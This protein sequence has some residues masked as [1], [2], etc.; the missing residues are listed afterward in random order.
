ML[1]AQKIFLLFTLFNVVSFNFVSGN[2]ITLYALRLGAG[3]FLVGAL[4]SFVPLARLLPL[5]GRLMVPR[6][7]ITRLMGVFWFVRYLVM[8]PVLFAPLFAG[9]G[10]PGTALILC[11][12]GV[13]GFNIARGIAITGYNPVLG[14]IT[15]GRD[16]GSYIAKNQVVVHSTSILTGIITALLLGEESPLFIY[17]IILA[18][19][20]ASGI[21]ASQFVFRLPEPPRTRRAVRS[22]LV[23]GVKRSLGRKSVRKFYLV[24]FL[25]FLGLAMIQ[26]FLIVFMRLVYGQGDN[27]VVYLTVIGSVGAI[28]TAFL[29]GFM[30]DRIGAKP[31][32]FVFA[33]LVAIPLVPLMV[34][35]PLMGVGLWLYAGGIFFLFMMGQAGL[36]N[37]AH[38]YFFAL[39]GPEERLNLGILYSMT[40]GLA[41]TLGSLLGGTLLAQLQRSRLAVGEVFTIYFGILSALYMVVLFLAA[42]LEKLGAYGIRDA[43]TFLLSPRD[44]RAMGLLHRLDR[45]RT[46]EEEKTFIQALGE[47]GSDISTSDLLQRLRSPRFTLRAEALRALYHLSPDEDVKRALISEAKNHRYTTA[48]IAAELIG[49]HGIQ[50]G[51]KVLRQALRSRD[52]FLSGKSMVALARLGDRQSLTTITGILERTANP[53]LIIHAAT[54]CELFKEP[55][56]IPLLIK[57]LKQRTSAYVRDEI[58]LSVAGIL[59]VDSF[60]YPLYTRFLER[61]SHGIAELRDFLQTSARRQVKPALDSAALE[62]LLN[63]LAK[64]KRVFMQE[65]D[66]LLAQLQVASGSAEAVEALQSGTTDAHYLRLD[67]F[68]FLVA[69]VIIWFAAGSPEDHSSHASR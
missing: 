53:R 18:L 44:L 30:V 47:S 17:T 12:V 8:A 38:T 32:Y 41:G 45:S 22:G 24:L 1:R 36:G 58:I 5:V 13:L 59:G 54:A 10:N 68:C 11:I 27:S 26:P 28:A 23:A 6:F 31:L 42:G 35:P 21:V 4:A 48:Y 65:A 15:T 67:R 37:A 14:G 25:T 9:S 57:K 49:V 16:R 39:I 64:D 55:L 43:L 40:T 69:A 20:M 33:G 2:I 61:G 19:G 34:S 50:E 63:R 7:G 60:F 66:R 46:F 56:T 52:Y 3:S 62:S 29:I 51:T